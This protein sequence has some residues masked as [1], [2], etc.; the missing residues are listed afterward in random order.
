MNNIYVG[1]TL[2]ELNRIIELMCRSQMN[3]LDAVLIARLKALSEKHGRVESV[4]LD[5]IP[6]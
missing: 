3:R 4:D 6:F 1:M 5:E 2:V